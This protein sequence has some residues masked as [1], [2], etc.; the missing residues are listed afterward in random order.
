MKVAAHGS[1]ARLTYKTLGYNKAKNLSWI[2]VDLETG[3]RHQ[4]RVQMA[5]AGFPLVGDTDYGGPDFERI[6]LHA[7]EYALAHEGLKLK[8]ESRDSSFDDFLN[9]NFVS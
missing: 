3:V 9:L 6:M 8:F 2:Q 7:Y 4:I 1:S 5:H